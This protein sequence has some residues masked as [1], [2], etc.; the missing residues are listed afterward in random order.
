MAS[1]DFARLAPPRGARIAVVGAGIG[2]ALTQAAIEIGLD[3]AALARRVS[4]RWRQSRGAAPAG[5]GRVAE[6]AGMVG[7]ILFLLGP[8][9]GWVNG[10]VLHVNGGGLMP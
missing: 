6:P 5:V 2:C 1:T 9:S 10:Q 4:V 3:V 8:A 7:P